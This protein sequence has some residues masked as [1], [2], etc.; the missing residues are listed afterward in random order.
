MIEERMW[1]ENH[2]GIGRR[3]LHASNTSEHCDGCSK[4]EPP[5]KWPPLPDNLDFIAKGSGEDTPREGV[6]GWDY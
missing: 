5:V 6:K 4:F 2:K 3:T 1:C